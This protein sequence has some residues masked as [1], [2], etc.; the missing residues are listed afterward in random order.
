MTDAHQDHDE[1]D[2]TD[3]TEPID[4]WPAPCAY[5]HRA[6]EKSDGYRTGR[7]P[8]FCTDNDDA[9]FKA[10]RLERQRL[11]TSPGLPGQVVRV[12]DATDKLE[13]V[14]TDLRASLAT[15][16][17]PAGIEAK[18]AE[19]RATIETAEA[20]RQQAEA[21][22]QVARAAQGAAEQTA[23]A[24]KAARLRAVEDAAAAGE[25][26]ERADALATAERQAADHARQDAE[27]AR[28]AE[29]VAEEEKAAAI[30]RA[31]RGERVAVEAT[32]ARVEAE[33]ERDAAQDERVALRRQLA[34][35]S[36]RLTDAKAQLQA[37]AEH[38]RHAEERA[39]RADARADRA[40]ARADRAQA[41][42]AGN[43][44]LSADSEDR[45]WRLLP[46]DVQDQLISAAVPI[47]A[48]RKGRLAD[49][50]G[51]LRA[52]VYKIATRAPVTDA[53]LTA[54][55]EADAHVW[56]SARA[57]SHAQAWTRAVAAAREAMRTQP[58]E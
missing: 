3:D 36:E 35:E 20:A 19:A 48:S 56:G 16:T 13:Q 37:A 25:E 50:P 58:D 41:T 46:S 32:A 51:N 28:R 15:V 11:R 8:K 5:C 53:L 14:V 27:H 6:I 49:L 17:S 23:E 34:V 22:A 26:R 1:D 29:Q 4:Y 47:S 33:R 12:E 55:V 10:A 43:E 31:E 9:C 30:E 45:L 42:E 57:G 44:G 52:A 7:P 2:V 38:T 21:E 54:V 18:Y 24:A 39:D 40:E